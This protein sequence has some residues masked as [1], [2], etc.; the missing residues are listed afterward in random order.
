MAS[1]ADDY[2][3]KIDGITGESAAGK[4]PA[5]SRSTGSTGA[6]R[7]SHASAARPAAPAPARRSSTSSRSRRTSTRP[8]PLLF[9]KLA[10]GAPLK[11]MELIARKAGAT[12]TGVIYQRY[13]FNPVFVTSQRQRGDGE[14]VTE[15]LKLTY[16]AMQMTN[17][18]QAADGPA[19]QRLR[20][21][22][23]DHQHRLDVASSASRLR[24]AM[25]LF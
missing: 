21:L 6:S 22:E 16:G 2:F 12:G 19:H 18:R 5:R 11:G 23:P 25:N 15:T 17:V 10:T 13:Y 8:A 7:T 1:A 20:K 4:S 3:L 14:S 24:P 9:Q